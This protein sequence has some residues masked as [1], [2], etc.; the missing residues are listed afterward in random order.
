MNAAQS[1]ESPLSPELQTGKCCVTRRL[2][3]GGGP[4]GVRSGKT[5]VPGCRPSP[6]VFIALGRAAGRRGGHSQGKKL[7][8][9]DC[10][11]FGLRAQMSIGLA[12][13]PPKMCIR[14]RVTGISEVKGER[15]TLLRF[16]RKWGGVISI[17]P[18]IPFCSPKKKA[19]S[20]YKPCSSSSRDMDRL[21]IPA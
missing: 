18:G 16:L 21:G 1:L 10:C 4:G 13:P 3:K 8:G 12:A 2:G 6:K 15:R 17:V 11:L 7:R 5:A 20:G 9:L 19:G 14:S